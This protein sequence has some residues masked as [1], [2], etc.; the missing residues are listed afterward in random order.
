MLAV[1]VF[2]KKACTWQNI[3]NPGYCSFYAINVTI[4][5]DVQYCPEYFH[6]LLDTFSG[7]HVYRI[8]TYIYKYE[9]TSM[10]WCTWRSKVEVFN[11]LTLY[12]FETESHF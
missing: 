6:G 12:I 4:L 2:I 10:Y 8:P 5:G 7:L 1:R 9:H 3:Q 11:G